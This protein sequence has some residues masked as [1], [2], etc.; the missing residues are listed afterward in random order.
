[1]DQRCTMRYAADIVGCLRAWA[2]TA[3][4]HARTRLGAARVVV[5]VTEGMYVAAILKASL[6]L[7]AIP[8]REELLD[9][10]REDW[11]Q[12]SSGSDAV[13]FERFKDAIF[14]KRS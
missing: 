12:D 7:S 4:A 13:S 14:R 11:T 8:T 3:E 1:M 6:A 2:R 10:A 9:S 5:S